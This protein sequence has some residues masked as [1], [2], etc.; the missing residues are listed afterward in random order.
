MPQQL[1][2]FLPPLLGL[3]L[4][5]GCI[6]TGPTTG[7]L[8]KVWGRRGISEGRLH[9]PRAMAVNDEDEIF[10]VDM[11]DLTGLLRVASFM[12]LGLALLGVAYLYQRILKGVA[13]A[14][15]E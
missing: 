15:E 10:L 9:K 8:E 2:R 5:A 13:G 4:C 12:G 1:M 3:V 6:K 7:K 11:S 14:D